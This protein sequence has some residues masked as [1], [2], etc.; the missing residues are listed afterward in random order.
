MKIQTT[1]ASVL[2]SAAVL[3]LGLTSPAPA[4]AA[5]NP[6]AKAD[7]YYAAHLGPSK[8]WKHA[9]KHQKHHAKLTYLGQYGSWENG[10]KADL[11][12]AYQGK[13]SNPKYVQPGLKVWVV[14]TKGADILF[15]R[16]VEGV[17][18]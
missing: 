4:H 14:K 13:V 17:C 12:H 1:I 2:A 7:A 3:G 16:F 8:A 11:R 18:N 6:Q 10:C 5:T 15:G 9:T